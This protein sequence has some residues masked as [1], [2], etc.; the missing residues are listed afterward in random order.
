M[1]RNTDGDTESRAAG[2]DQSLHCSIQTHVARGN[3]NYDKFLGN[4][5]AGSGE[6]QF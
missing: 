3:V 5:L 2:A 6:E 4:R 1:Q